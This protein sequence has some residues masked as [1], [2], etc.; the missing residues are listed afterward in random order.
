VLI[1]PGSGGRIKCWPLENFVTLARRLSDRGDVGVLFV[2]GEAEIDR[3]G[4]D[5]LGPLAESFP[6]LR[7]GELV[8]LAGLLAQAKAYTGNDSG[9]SHLAAALGTPTLALFGA[10]NP[11]HFAPVGRTVRVVQG[12][13]MAAIEVETVLAGLDALLRL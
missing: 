11:V 9:P 5:A 4:E 12:E 6:L 3:W 8:Q 2:V 13:T 10:T 7:C 1:H